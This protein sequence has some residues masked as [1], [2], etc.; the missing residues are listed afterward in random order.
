MQVDIDKLKVKITK[1]VRN[2][3]NT[4][5]KPSLPE[6][7]KELKWLMPFIQPYVEFA[8]VKLELGG[9]KKIKVSERLVDHKLSPVMT[10]CITKKGYVVDKELGEHKDWTTKFIVKD[11]GNSIAL[12]TAKVKPIFFWS[13]KKKDE[14]KASITSEF[15]IA[16]KA[17]KLG[18]GPEVFDKFICYNKGSYHAFK[19]IISDYMQGVSIAEWL[20]TNPSVEEQDRVHD[21]VKSK[22][23][24][25]HANGIIHNS[26]STGN[27]ILVDDGK[28]VMIT[29]YYSASDASNK[30]MWEYNKWIVNDRSILSDIKRNAWTWSNASEVVVY[31]IHELMKNK[32]VVIKGL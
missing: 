27:I 1:Y 23:D 7:Q 28:D 32:D 15:E 5:D 29:D 10:K 30:K 18:L 14:M 2:F 16:E 4:P 19:V 21:L 9:L 22:L 3:Y 8:I 24:I 20:K 17:H 12:K 6:I 31:V 11:K 26:I 25:M 13:Y